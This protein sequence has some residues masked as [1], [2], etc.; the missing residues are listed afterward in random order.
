MKLT[1]DRPPFFCLF[2]LIFAFTISIK[3]Q[4]ALPPGSMLLPESALPG[5]ESDVD[6]ARLIRDNSSVVIDRG[7]EVYQQVCHNCHGDVNLPGSIPHSLRFAEGQFQHGNDP[8]TI[9]QTITRGWRL[10]APQVS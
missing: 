1:L 7:R 9:Y 2:G 6:H 5:Y 8:Y 4:P 3:A 10:M